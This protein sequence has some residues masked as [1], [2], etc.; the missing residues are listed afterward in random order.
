MRK[1]Q[2]EGT[3]VD[4]E[5]L[6]RKMGDRKQTKT[7]EQVVKEVKEG[8]LAVDA[9]TGDPLTAEQITE[10]AK[11]LAKEGKRLEVRTVPPVSGG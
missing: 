11:E 7:A 3:L 10:R 4:V 6:D 5:E 8:K 2:D 9:K 1:M